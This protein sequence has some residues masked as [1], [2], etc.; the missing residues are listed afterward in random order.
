MKKAIL[1]LSVTL[2]L[3]TLTVSMMTSVSAEDVLQS[4]SWGT[5]SWSL[6]ETTGE[7]VISGTGEMDS[8]A[9]SPVWL[10]HSGKIQTVVIEQGVTSIG[11]HAFKNCGNL[12]SVT[13]P[14]SVT[15]IGY[16]SFWNCTKLT[17]ITIHDG[18][19]DVN[20]DAFTGCSNIATATVPGNAIEAL[21]KG[22]KEIT[23]TSGTS[24]PSSAFSGQSSLR[25]ICFPDTVTTIGSFAFYNCTNLTS[26]HLPDGLTS[27]GHQA[28]QNCK[29]LESIHIPDT[30]TS[31]G[32]SAFTYC[33]SLRSATLPKSLTSIGDSMFKGCESL[34]AITIPE[35]VEHIESNAF[36]YCESLSEI[37][38][39]SGVTTLSD[40]AFSGCD[41]LK[42]I[43]IPDGITSI[44]GYA[45]DTTRNVET[46]VMPIFAISYIPKNNLKTV[47]FTSGTGIPAKTFSGCTLL[48][49]VIFCGTESEWKSLQKNKDWLKDLKNTK[50]LYHDCQWET[51]DARHNG[52][53]VACN[54]IVEG[55]HAWDSGVITT[56]PTHLATGIKT[57]SCIVCEKEK[58]AVLEKTEAHKYSKWIKHDETQHKKICECEHTVYDAHTYGSWT[59]VTPSTEETEGSRKKI[60]VCGHEITEPTPVLIHEY[61]ATVVKPNCT[62]QGYILHACKNCED[63][64]TDTYVNAIGHIYDN[65][66]DATCNECNETRQ[67]STE[68]PPADTGIPDG[69]NDKDPGYGILIASGIGLVLLA[70]GTTIGIFYKKKKRQ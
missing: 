1:F 55:E 11:N 58:T 43:V 24:I 16:L 66:Q 65:D 70:A 14:D 29:K 17:E 39:P 9:D 41:G 46:A 49:K 42:K 36:Q 68:Q 51:T 22:I 28:F 60:C 26:I 62:E 57:I 3:L 15:R 37:V 13:I 45:F 7:L 2:I 47:V 23:V 10:V 63:R 31:L 27:I 34:T 50:F 12:T 4:G 35:N 19:T 5:L 30:V 59:V 48:E 40:F 61:G 64:Y 69:T 38:L 20:E 25:S 21:P 6:N 52:T 56:L 44:S 67:L 32:Q 8:L 53:C 18:C 33:E 54:T